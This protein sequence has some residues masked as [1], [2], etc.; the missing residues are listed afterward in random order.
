MVLNLTVAFGTLNAVIFY[1]NILSA[2]SNTFLP[3]SE[4]SLFTVF[5]AM[6]NLEIG[7]DFC[8]INGLNAYWKTWLQLVFPAYVFFLTAVIILLGRSLMKFSRLIGKRNTVATLATLILLSYAK[9][10]HMVISIL[11]YKVQAYPPTSHSKI[12]AL[13]ATV[14]YLTGKHTVLFAAALFI[15]LA[16]AFYTVILFSWQWLFY[17]QDKFLFK[18][19]RSQ[20]LCQFLEPYHAPYTFKHRYWT[21]LLLVAH[22]V[23]YVCSAVNESGSAS[24]DLPDGSLYDCKYPFFPQI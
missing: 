13:D 21:G 8:F 20:K 18:W 23:L 15:L 19:V 5:I 17:Y 1:A 3:F 4:P 11:S 12:W 10:L 14:D 2:T 24:V 7:V 16:G 22:I 9:L 6:F